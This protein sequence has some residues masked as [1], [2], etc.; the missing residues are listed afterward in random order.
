MQIYTTRLREEWAD[1]VLSEHG[2]LTRV[3]AVAGVD[4]STISRWFNRRTE[5]S[6]RCVGTVL[7]KFPTTFEDA[8]VVTV[9]EVEQRRARIV[10]RPTGRRIEPQ[11]DPAA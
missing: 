2:T 9:E 5:A 10:T 8:F 1:R 4:V 7:T 11:A 6:G 3:A